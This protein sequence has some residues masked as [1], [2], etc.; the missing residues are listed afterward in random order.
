M[1]VLVVDD[2][3]AMRMI[4]KRTLKKA[5]I[6]APV[7]EA[8]NGAVA[9]DAIRANSYD[10]VLSDWNMPEMNGI[11]LLQALRAE[12]HP[13]AFGFVT[14]EVT[15]EMRELAESS[16]AEFLIGKPFTPDD[17]ERHLGGRL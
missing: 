17:F 5:G 1:T 13:V 7:E 16:G 15:S 14:S 10:F 9:L 12:D 8:E 4:V 11:E 3:R 6:D 2:S